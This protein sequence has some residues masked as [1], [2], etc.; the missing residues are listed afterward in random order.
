MTSDIPEWIAELVERETHADTM[1]ALT[2]LERQW[3]ADWRAFFQPTGA[4]RND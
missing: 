1:R 2:P 4:K 3:L